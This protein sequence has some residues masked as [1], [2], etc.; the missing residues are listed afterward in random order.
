M[1]LSTLANSCCSSNTDSKAKTTIAFGGN[2]NIKCAGW[3]KPCIA[4]IAMNYLYGIL[5][6]KWMTDV[7]HRMTIP[8][9]QTKAARLI[10][11]AARGQ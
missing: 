11:V 2:M 9:Q 5:K 7:L 6:D 8:H 10:A 3:S 1:H 4:A